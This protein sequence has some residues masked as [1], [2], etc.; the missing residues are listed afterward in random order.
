M[1]SSFHPFFFSKIFSLFFIIFHYIPSETHQKSNIIII[2]IIMSYHLHWYPRPSLPTPP[3]RP[4]LPVAFRGYI[5]YLHRAAV[6]RFVLVARP[7]EGVHISTS[8]RS[9][10]LLLQQCPA[11]LA[12]LILIVFVMVSRMIG[13]LSTHKPIEQ[14]VLL[15][16]ARDIMVIVGG[17]GHGNQGSNPRLGCLVWFGLLGFMAYQPL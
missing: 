1:F 2:I 3:C 14:N 11:C 7:C 9:P 8:L 13:E 10:S 12:R 15:G 17:N 4:L 5:P 16:G 6:C